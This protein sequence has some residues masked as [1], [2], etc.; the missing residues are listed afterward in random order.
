MLKKI[1]K[2]FKE[3][4]DCRITCSH[5]HRRAKTR[6]MRTLAEISRSPYYK[7]SQGKTYNMRRLYQ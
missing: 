2:R 3:N 5:N 7:K 4:P 1:P 6:D